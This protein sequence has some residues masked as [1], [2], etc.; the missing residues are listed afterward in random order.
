M[1]M[2]PL[3]AGAATVFTGASGTDAQA[4]ADAANWDNG[5][6]DNA[7][8]DGNIPT[9]TATTYAADSD[10]N[11]NGTWD[12]DSTLTGGNSRIDDGV[13]TFNG[14]SS[15]TTTNVIALARNGGTGI[16]NIFDNATVSADT[17]LKI[18][19]AGAGIINQFGGTLTVGADLELGNVNNGGTGVYNMSGGVAN[20]TFLSF[21]TD[22]ANIFNFTTGS[23]GILNISN[24]GV[25]YTTDFENFISNGDITRNGTSASVGDFLINF[26]GS[27]TS[28]QLGS[29]P[30]PGTGA[31]GLLGLAILLRRRVR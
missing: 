26:D 22:P 27:S 17:G 16:I 29:V 25:D 21:A 13:L 11:F 2:I 1:S 9:G 20:G 8:N 15:Y 30:E 18:G 7:G 23:V 4:L 28:I 3:S 6:P 12:G 24:A 19:R 5:L 31:F 14:T 10:L